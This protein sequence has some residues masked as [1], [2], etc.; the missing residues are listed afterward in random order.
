[1]R[2]AEKISEVINAFSPEPLKA[3]QM[4][5]FYCEG[6]MEYRMNDK[7][8]SPIED[9]FDS[10]C[11]RGNDKAFLLLGH[12]GCGK[13]TELNRMSQRL[14]DEGYMVRTV[15][16]GMDLDLFNVVYSDLFIL[17]G[18]ALME[19]AQESGGSI[20]EDVLASI[21]RFWDEGTEISISQRI[22]EVN[23]ESGI[24]AGTS[25]ILARIL[26]VFMKIKADLK[27]NEETRNE[28]RKKMMVRS[29]EWVKLL[30]QVAETI[31][32]NN[33]GKYPIIIFED[34]DKLNPEDA[35]KVF[36]NYVAILTGMSFP[37]V[38][39]FPVGLSYDKR[40]SALEAYFEVKTLPMIKIETMKG[41]P[42]CEGIES[43]REIVVK[44]ACLDIFEDGVLEELIHYT[45]GSLRDLF[46]AINTSAKR[47]ERRNSDVISAEDA[48]RALSELET[49]LTRRIEK[50][51]YGFLLNI[52]NGNKEMIE[53]KEMLLKMLQASA[54]LEYNGKR[55]HNIHPLIARFFKEQGL[56][57]DAGR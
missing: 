12:R 33:G 32:G 20:H 4:E 56:I 27:Y 17:M 19:M 37:V 53:D 54:V 35:W 30:N 29:S 21:V 25:G 11:G 48:Q 9:I 34:L 43:V 45:G 42:F 15:S 55:W 1:M 39:T 50:N 7:Y 46:H 28:Y 22:E 18:E 36:Y 14:R 38:Y 2:Y 24:E 49:S 41:E 52:Y 51:D 10:C 57:S 44:R 3:E 26:N 5:Q 31:A 16:C 6:T 40:F 8:S 23:A 47:A 13:S